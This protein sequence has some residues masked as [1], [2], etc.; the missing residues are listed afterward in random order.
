MTFEYKAHITSF[1]SVYSSELN[2]WYR[3]GWKF[4][5][6]YE[7]G[8]LSCTLIIYICICWEICVCLD[9][10]VHIY[11]WW[12]SEWVSERSNASLNNRQNKQQVH[13]NWILWY[14]CKLN[15]TF[16]LHNSTRANINMNRRNV[17]KT[18]FRYIQCGFLSINSNFLLRKLY[19]SKHLPEYE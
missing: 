2:T 4:P 3:N 19:Y 11:V 18:E 7:C 1:K 5:C 10:C 8:W 13:K 12:V 14:W 9:V 16:F 17:R 15:L 6:F